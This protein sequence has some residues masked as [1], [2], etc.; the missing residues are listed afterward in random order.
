MSDLRTELERAGRHAPPLEDDPYDRLRTRR[1]RQARRGRVAAG[2]VSLA[3]AV[4]AIAGLWTAFRPH[5]TE[6]PP[7]QAASGPT[8]DLSVGPNQYVYQKVTAYSYGPEGD[9]PN[10][11]LFVER[12]V[13]RSWYRRDDSGRSATDGTLS[14]F[15][16]ADRQADQGLHDTP[17]PTEQTYG[18]GAYPQDT[19]DLS[20]LSTDPAVLLQQLRDR[21]SQTGSSPEPPISPGPG[22]GADTGMLWGAI[23]TLIDAPATTPTQRAALFEVASQLQGVQVTQTATDPVGR[24]A[25]LLS[26]INGEGVES[27]WWFDPSS[28][29]LLAQRY[30][31]RT[32]SMTYPNG[33]VFT[34][35]V[36][37]SAGVAD[38][39]DDGGSLEKSFVPSPITDPPA[40]PDPR[41]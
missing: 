22:Q 2:T 13:A 23:Q 14:Y 17:V 11:P 29:Q 41:H 4:V 32:D 15:T 36:V 40:M 38:S 20:S 12:D 6:P 28:E 9:G 10:W 5:N 25:T 27:E 19:G 37:A 35:N 7:S 3:V 39:T 24:P 33:T 31:V 1:E 8:A 16:E 18:P 26:T 34:I 21:S 30:T